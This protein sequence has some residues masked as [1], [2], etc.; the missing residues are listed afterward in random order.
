MG[1]TE[2]D[3]PVLR[4]DEDAG[5]GKPP[6]CFGGS[7]IVQTGVIERDIDEDGLVVAAV[8][9]GNAVG[10]AELFG[11]DGAG[12]GQEREGEGVLLEGEVILP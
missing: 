3:G 10:E 2:E 8:F 4:D 1:F 9:R 12:I 7:L 5:E 6:A 11:Y